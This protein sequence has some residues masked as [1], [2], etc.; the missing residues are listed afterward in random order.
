MRAPSS[1]N[2]SAASPSRARASRT[3]SA[4]SASMG[5]TG[6]KRR[7][8][9]RDS[10][11]SPSSNAAFATLGRSPAAI[12]ARRTRSAGTPAACATASITSP[13]SAPWR[14]SPTTRLTRK[15]C[16]SRVAR[17]SSSLKRRNFSPT[18]PFPATPATRANAASTSDNVSVGDAAAESDAAACTPANP[19]PSF[20]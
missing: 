19:T 13:S 17:A 2:S 12:T 6:R 14:S 4:E 1:L 8:A 18:E 7:I 5:R 10:P 3:S 11:A 16:S 15:R 9:K 20:A